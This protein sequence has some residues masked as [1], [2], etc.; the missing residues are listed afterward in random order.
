[1]ATSVAAHSATSSSA[2]F[3]G[4]LYSTT[5][6]TMAMTTQWLE[7]CHGCLPYLQDL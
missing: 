2:G 6:S 5:V 1:M 4:T 3:A 7:L